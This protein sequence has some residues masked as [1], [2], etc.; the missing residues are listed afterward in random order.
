MLVPSVSA[1]KSN[2]VTIPDRTGDLGKYNVF[3]TVGNAHGVALFNNTWGDNAPVLQAK[4]V[5]MVSVS[6]G[7]VRSTYIFGMKLAADLPQAGATLPP[8]IVY[9][10]WNLWI[11]DSP[12]SPTN[13]AKTLY[14]AWLQ[15]DGSSYSAVLW[16]VASGSLTSLPFK[17]VDARTFQIQISPASIGNLASFWWSAGTFVAMHAFIEPPWLIDINDLGVAPGQVW[18]DMPWPSP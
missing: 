4:Y 17:I 7:L 12:W 5:D 15:F 6:F 2:V 16:D 1:G 10:V 8:G 3:I 13:S 9:L 14:Q 18:F 11:E